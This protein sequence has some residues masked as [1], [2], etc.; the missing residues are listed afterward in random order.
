[1]YTYPAEVVAIVANW[2]TTQIFVKATG[3]QSKPG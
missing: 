2:D 3:G 1:M